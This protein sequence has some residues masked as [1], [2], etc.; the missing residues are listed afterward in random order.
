ML[1]PLIG[2]G[3]LSCTDSSSGD[4][5]G[6]AAV[7]PMSRVSMAAMRG[8]VT[9]VELW[10]VWCSPCIRSMPDIQA[11]WEEHRFHLAGFD[12][13]VVNTGWRGDNLTVVE[14]WLAANPEYDFPVYFEDRPDTLTF[15]YQYQVNSIPRSL[16][17]DKNG[18]LRY[19]DHPAGVP[20]DFIDDLLRE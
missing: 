7:T 9:Y 13:L 12:L 6:D 5:P 16:I 1:L 2:L 11:V 8:R 19:N 20:A 3:F 14:D 17:F 18:R 15:A 10:G 4:D